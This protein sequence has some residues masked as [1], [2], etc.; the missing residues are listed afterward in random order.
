MT[1]VEVLERIER[2][3]RAVGGRTIA[4]SAAI[5]VF[6]IGATALMTVLFGGGVTLTPY[7]QAITPLVEQHNVIV[8]EWN[9][10]LSDYNAI[11][12]ESPEIYDERAVDGKKMTQQLADDT[13]VLIVAWDGVE[14]PAGTATAHGLS[15]DAIRETQSGF[16]ELSIYFSNIVQYGVAFDEDLQAGTSRLN[17][18]SLIWAEAKAA[19]ILAN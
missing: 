1:T 3:A 4:I 9:A 2:P 14:T 12:L 8:G 17:R 18:A 13:Q 5:L 11:A 16:I 15:R 7:E 6:G 10:F 19:A